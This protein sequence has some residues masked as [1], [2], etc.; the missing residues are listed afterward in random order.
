MMKW[1]RSETSLKSSAYNHNGQNYFE[2]L[3]AYNS[4]SSHLRRVLLAKCVIDSRNK[5]CTSRKKQFCKQVEC[6][7]HFTKRRITNDLIDRLAYDSLHHPADILQIHYNS[8]YLRRD[9]NQRYFFDTYDYDAIRSQLSLHDHTICSRSPIFKPNK[10]ETFTY[11]DKQMG[12][13][14]RK[15]MLK[16]Q[17]MSHHRHDR[18]SIFYERVPDF[19][20]HEADHPST[21]VDSTRRNENFETNTKPDLTL[22]QKI[23]AKEE[24][25]KYVNFVYEITHDILYNRLYTDE[26]LRE[27]FKKHL[28][29]NK[30]FLN[31]LKLALGVPDDSDDEE[32]DIL[33]Y[34]R[35]FSNNADPR[36]PTPPKVLNEN[37]I[38]EKLMS[39]QTENNEKKRKSSVTDKSVVLVDANPEL[40][41]T[42]RD[43]LTS[44]IE[45]NINPDQAEKIY[46]RLS[47]KSQELIHRFTDLAHENNQQRTEQSNANETMNINDWLD[48]SL[49]ESNN[50]NEMDDQEKGST[51]HD[52]IMQEDKGVQI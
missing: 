38:I 49:I 47:A 12:E 42:E 37:K 29:R 2:Q 11:S 28:E 43:V 17:E 4:M 6:K 19:P 7:P 26:Q 36:P 52:L 20:T 44:L 45:L 13:Q 40:I 3:T 35:R 22:N 8:R 9:G 25:A 21:E 41:L 46:K 48:S 24:E 10:L 50:S 34:D 27:V 5:N 32:L 15:T 33:I 14:K 1:N 39:F 16:G 31:M 18:D 23:C 30:E 51:T